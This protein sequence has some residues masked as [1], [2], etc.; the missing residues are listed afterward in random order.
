MTQDRRRQGQRTSEQKGVLA[1][2]RFSFSLG[3]GV[4]PAAGSVKPTAGFTFDQVPPTAPGADAGAIDLS[5]GGLRGVARASSAAIVASSRA[6]VGAARAAIVRTA[7]IASSS[8]RAE[9]AAGHA[10]AHTAAAIH[11]GARAEAV[12]ICAILRALVCV[13]QAAACGRSGSSA[14]RAADLPGASIAIAGNSRAH[15]DADLT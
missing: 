8:D 2:F 3:A 6:F 12:S 9:P 4:T 1:V 15:A 13:L 11:R 7:D 10:I 5:G 14:A